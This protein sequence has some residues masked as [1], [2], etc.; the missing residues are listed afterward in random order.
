M[1]IVLK[2]TAECVAC[3]CVCVCVCG[4]KMPHPSHVF[5]IHFNKCNSR[6]FCAFSIHFK[7]K[8]LLLTK[9]TE[10]YRVKNFKANVCRCSQYHG[11]DPSKAKKLVGE[12]RETCLPRGVGVTNQR[13]KRN[14]FGRLNFVV[15]Q[16]SFLLFNS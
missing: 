11:G 5:L 2:T 3:V 7:L 4:K 14:R 10:K 1:I 12:G 6:F 16:V 8:R 13:T 15:Y 9:G